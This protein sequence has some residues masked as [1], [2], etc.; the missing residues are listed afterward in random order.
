MKRDAKVV[1][2][3]FKQLMDER[4]A[5]LDAVIAELEKVK[6]LQREQQ[7]VF[8]ELLELATIPDEE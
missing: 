8:F 5:A 4:D 1:L 2:A 7:R 6:A 3:R